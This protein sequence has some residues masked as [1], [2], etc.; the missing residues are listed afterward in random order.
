MSEHRSERVIEGEVRPGWSRSS[1]VA[2]VVVSFL[3]ATIVGMTSAHSPWLSGDSGQSSPPPYV[4]EVLAVG[5]AAGLCILVALIWIRMPRRTASKGRRG[6]PPIAIDEIRQ[7]I[8][9]G[10][11]VLIAG[12]LAIVVLVLAFWF[13]LEQADQVVA[14]PPQAATIGDTAGLPPKTPAPSVSRAFDWFLVALVASIAVILPLSL[15]ARRSLRRADD[16]AQEMTD[17]PESVVRAVGESIDQIERDPDARRAIIR[18]YAQM[19]HAFDDAGVPRRPYEAPFEYLG[20]ALRGVR[21]SPPAAGRLASL[22]ERARF[23]Q[24][25]VDAGTKDDAIGALREIER[26][27]QGP[28]S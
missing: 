19:E 21:V 13:L 18:A 15:L 28:S 16:A 27:M 23:S 10:T 2:V 12:I 17:A 4:G 1:V 22:F 25:A 7:G 14:P 20:R 11:L 8:P 3:L 6:R 24:H 5:L 26:Q 9:G